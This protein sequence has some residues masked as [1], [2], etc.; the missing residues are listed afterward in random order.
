MRG[1]STGNHSVFHPFDVSWSITW[2]LSRGDA[3]LPLLKT[4][5]G[6][7]TRRRPLSRLHQSFCNVDY[8]IHRLLSLVLLV[9]LSLTGSQPAAAYGVLTHHQLI[10]EAWASGIVPLLLSRYPSLSPEQLREAH[11]FAYGGC[12]IQDFGYYPFANGFIAGLTHYVRSG[13][14]VQSLFRN[15]QNANE[16]AFA[17]GALSHFIGDSIGHSEATN[18]SVALVFPK[19]RARYG[20]SVNYA[21]DKRAHGQVELAFDANQ[22][23]RG[24]LAPSKYLHEIGLEVPRRQLA[25]AFYETYG[26]TAKEVMGRYEP[27]MRTY[28]FGARIFLPTFVYA[29]ALLHG[30]RFPPDTRR[31]RI[32]RV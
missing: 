28:R 19:L 27:V 6:C 26:L 17:I 30:H 23:A 15:A 25:A 31:S 7:R 32:R 29:E 24:R 11:A 2:S 8:P 13:D 5:Q 12:L 10:D 1:N 22:F 16:L 21:Q 14:F 3:I 4:S 9:G 18:P 20:P